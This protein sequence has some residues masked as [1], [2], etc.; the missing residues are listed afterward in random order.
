MQLTQVEN[1]FVELK[2]FQLKQINGQMLSGQFRSG[3]NTRKRNIFESS[4]HCGNHEIN[5][6]AQ[7]HI[8]SASSY[9]FFGQI[10]GMFEYSIK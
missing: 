8:Y 5:T 10:E 2:S 4:G 9:K 7:S 1:S 6:R 3:K